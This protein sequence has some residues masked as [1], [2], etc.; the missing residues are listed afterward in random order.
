MQRLDGVHW[1]EDNDYKKAVGQLRL[2]LSAVFSPF[3]VYGL[4]VL[5][6]NAVDEAVKL[7][8]DF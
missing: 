2:Q 5:I 4:D 6:P 8:E 1:L 7:C 3:S